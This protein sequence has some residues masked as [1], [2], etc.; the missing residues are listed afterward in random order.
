MRI[1]SLLALGSLVLATATTVSAAPGGE[2]PTEPRS[3]SQ[4]AQSFAE[5]AGIREFTGQMIVRP[6]T[7][8]DFEAQG[9]D[10]SQAFA[11]RA[12]A[13]RTLSAYELIAH[14]PTTDEY[15]LRVPPGQTEEEMAAALMSSENFEF[16][17][18]DWL[19]APLAVAAP[20]QSSSSQQI[21]AAGQRPPIRKLNCPDDPYLPLQWHHAANRLNSCAAWELE[22]G[23]T[24]IQVAVC[25]TGIRKTHTDLQLH[26]LEGYNAVDQL[27]E[28]EGGNVNPV[29][30]HGTRTTGT[31]AA[32]GDNGIGVVGVGWNLSHRMLRVSNQSDGGAYLSALQHAART[33]VESGDRV[34]NIS[35]H[36]ASLSN[37]PTATYVKSQG[38][39]LLWGA[40]NTSSNHSHADRDADDLIVV[41]ATDQNDGLAS[42]ST[43]GTFIDLVAPGVGIMTTDYASDTAYVTADGT[44]YACPLTTGVCA[45]IWSAR[46]NLSPNDVE[47]ILKAGADDIGAPGLDVLFGHGRI[48][49]MNS[50]ALDGSAIPIAEFNATPTSGVSPLVVEFR[51]LSS[52]VPTSWAWDFGDGATSTLQNPVHTYTTSGSFS[53]SLTVTNAL[54]NDLAI[55]PDAVL[56]DVIPPIADFLASTTAGLSPLMV[57]FS[58]E[59]TGGVPSAWLW[60]FGD[61]NTSTL[62]D[63]TH[64]FATS[65]YY[66]VSLNVSNAYGSDLLVRNNYITVDFVPPVA[67]FSGGPVTGPS[68]YVVQFADE[69]VG[70]VATSW[71]WSFGD[72]G[73]SSAQHPAH[74]YTVPGTYTVRLRASNAYGEDTLW[75]YDYIEVGPGGPLLADFVGTPRT[76]PAPLSVDFTDRS[77]GNITTWEWDFGDG[78]T[79]TLQH[80]SHV[81]T[82]SGEYD[83][84]LQ[85]GNADGSDDQ[86]ELHVYIVVE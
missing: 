28:S 18:P 69:S 36:G 45:M 49:L 60:D 1:H 64:T 79:S 63:P 38:G 11:R 29:H 57:D 72:G 19:L 20:T 10:R 23:G 54:G 21:P 73:T 70:G 8:R 48:N 58:D 30:S 9:L 27:W 62:P 42:F 84:A 22:T 6:R 59:S 77:I 43:Y 12:E 85:V 71:Y 14:V 51:D 55:I 37:G 47:R 50:L 40:G 46:P 61:G 13:R 74:T 81:Y 80:P 76:G 5:I 25:D 75:R 53:V 41:G 78:T 31:V 17:Q 52:G 2:S 35:Y 16:A 82:S 15:I 86:L 44:S 33:A 67:A 34:I 56:V 32:N 26:R 68:P 83:V 3:P 39:L 65:G 24:S 66:T 4:R 7:R